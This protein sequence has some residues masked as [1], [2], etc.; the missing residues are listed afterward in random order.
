MSQ[1]RRQSSDGQQRP[2]GQR[3]SEKQAAKKRSTLPRILLTIVGIILILFTLSDL[4]LFL[5][6]KLISAD[7]SV[8]R[9]GGSDESLGDNLRYQW[10]VDWVF[11][12]DGKEYQG[13]ATQIGDPNGVDVSDEIRYFPFAPWINNLKSSTDPNPLHIIPLALGIF[14]VVV[15]NRK[16]AKPPASFKGKSEQ[17]VLD[18]M[19]DYD[20]SVE[21]YY[22]DK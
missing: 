17:Q 22:H 3:T 12:V 14:V 11:L 15:M 6:G 21:E 7:V 18:S 10:S 19:T 1:G 16:P 2:D 9:F 20:D 4:S 13:H 8:R 5:F